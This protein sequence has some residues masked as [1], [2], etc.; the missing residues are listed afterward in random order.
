MNAVAAQQKAAAK[1]PSYKDLVAGQLNVT[2]DQLTAAM[3]TA[4]GADGKAD[5][6]AALATA[7]NVTPAQVTAAFDAAR[8]Q[9]KAQ[10]KASYDAYVTALATQLGLAQD[11]VASA[12]ADSRGGCDK[13]GVPSQ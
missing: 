2:S 9:L 5:F 11:K 10:R 12:L 1:A 3:K 8:T 7:L 13:H 6:T 4:R